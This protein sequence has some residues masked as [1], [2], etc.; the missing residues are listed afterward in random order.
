MTKQPYAAQVCRLMVSTPWNT[1]N[2]PI[3]KEGK[4]ELAWSVGPRRTLYSK[5]GQMSSID[6]AKIRESPPS[7]D[8]CPNH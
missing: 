1:T 5:S 2:L 3:Q 4:A 6:Q 7:K 8:R